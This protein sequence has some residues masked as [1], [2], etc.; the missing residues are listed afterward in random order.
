[1]LALERV[2]KMITMTTYTLFFIVS[3]TTQAECDFWSTKTYELKE[4]C[5]NLGDRYGQFIVD[6]FD[7]L[8]E[9]KDASHKIYGKN[10]CS[11]K[12]YTSKIP[13]ARPKNL[14]P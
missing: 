12:F 3:F 9:C 8:K 14:V 4:S 5:F 7:S 2:F 10:Q 13:L 6:E 11:K 1:M